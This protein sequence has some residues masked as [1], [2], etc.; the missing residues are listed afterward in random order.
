MILH[1]PEVDGPGIDHVVLRDASGALRGWTTICAYP[2]GEAGVVCTGRPTPTS[3]AWLTEVL[4]GPLAGQAEG[5]LTADPEV[6]LQQHRK[7]AWRLVHAPA[8]HP[9]YFSPRQ[10]RR[11]D[12][13]A[14]RPTR[15][16]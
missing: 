1:W 3:E 15:P 12:R 10:T 7:W 11:A 13:R 8:T 5:V 6:A 4:S 9:E 14:T 16:G 2:R